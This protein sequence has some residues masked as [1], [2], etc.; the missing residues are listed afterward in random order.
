M[1]A[2]RRKEQGIAMQTTTDV[3]RLARAKVKFAPV[4]RVLDRLAKD[5]EKEHGRAA[6]LEQRSALKQMAGSAYTV[7]YAL[8]HRDEVRLSFT[9]IVVGE[10]AD[11]ILLQRQEHSGPRDIRGN[12]GQVDQQ[13]YRLKKI[14]ELKEAVQEKIVTHLQSRH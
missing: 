1:G 4:A 9:F 7:R 6:V 5:L 8:R 11:L 12:P 2:A 3:G 14:D 13:V 10:D